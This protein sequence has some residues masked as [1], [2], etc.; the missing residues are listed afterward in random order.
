[1]GI[2]LAK[3]APIQ[4][5]GDRQAMVLFNAAEIVKKAIT[6]PQGFSGRIILEPFPQDGTMAWHH[7]ASS[8]VGSVVRVAKQMA[9]D[10]GGS[11][12]DVEGADHITEK[13]VWVDLRVKSPE[14]VAKMRAY[15]G[16]GA[17]GLMVG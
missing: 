9:R 8:Q 6:A 14:T 15:L 4:K 12:S 5:P 1:M 7:I 16:V 17:S 3:I 2:F 13:N 11:L 10:A